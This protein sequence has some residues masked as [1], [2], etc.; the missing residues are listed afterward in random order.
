[1]Q[2][3]KAYKPIAFVPLGSEI[4]EREVQPEKAASPILST[5]DGIR[6]VVNAE[7]PENAL[8]GILNIL[9]VWQPSIIFLRL[10]QHLE[11]K[12]L[13]LHNNKFLHLDKYFLIY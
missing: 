6:R 3:A 13:C 11:Q 8:S 9:M 2:L 7:Q 12:Y 5:D 10:R 1:M 4:V